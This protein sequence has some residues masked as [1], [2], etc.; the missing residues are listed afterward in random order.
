MFITLSVI[1]VVF[2]DKTEM[3]VQKE[4]HQARKNKQTQD[5][6]LLK[7]HDVMSMSWQW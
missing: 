6:L 1:V 7:N 4:K 5:G 3:F 2:K